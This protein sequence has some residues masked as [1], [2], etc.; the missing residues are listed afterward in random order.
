MTHKTDLIQKIKTLFDKDFSEEL[1]L[2][3]QKAL[4]SFDTMQ[5]AKKIIELI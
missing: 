3:R 5:N 4:L 1:I 2:K